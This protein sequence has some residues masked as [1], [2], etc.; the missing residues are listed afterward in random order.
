[1]LAM[2]RRQAVVMN[3]VLFGLMRRMWISRVEEPVTEGRRD[4]VVAE[5]WFVGGFERNNHTLFF[6]GVGGVQG[7]GS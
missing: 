2:E 7:G 4:M 1:V 5:C 6:G 3:D